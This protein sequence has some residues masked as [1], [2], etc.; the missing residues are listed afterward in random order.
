[1]KTEIRDDQNVGQEGEESTYQLL[2][3]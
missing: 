3:V 1:V 2:H